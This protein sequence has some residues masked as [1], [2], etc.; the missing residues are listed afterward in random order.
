MFRKTYGIQYEQNTDLF[1][2]MF[3]Q[4]ETFYTQGGIDLGVK[5][6][7]FFVEL[8]QRMFQVSTRLEVLHV[9]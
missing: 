2:G 7:D 1:K 9:D 8:Y 5:M 6:D 4:L 3:H